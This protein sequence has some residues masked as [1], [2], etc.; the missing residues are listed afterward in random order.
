MI[1]GGNKPILDDNGN[2]V[3]D[4]DGNYVFT[5]VPGIRDHYGLIAQEVKSAIDLSGVEDFGGWQLD[6]KNDPSSN[7]G[8]VYHQ[9]IA[10]IIKAIQ[11]MSARLDALEG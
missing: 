9:F 8:L 2:K 3:T 4:E 5:S 10:P 6:D 11:E 7:Q 1:S